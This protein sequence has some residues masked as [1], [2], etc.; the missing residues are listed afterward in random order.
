[1]EKRQKVPLESHDFFAVL[2]QRKCKGRRPN[3]ADF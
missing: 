3:Y 2:R 1:M